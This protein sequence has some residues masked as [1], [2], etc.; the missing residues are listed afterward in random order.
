MTKACASFFAILILTSYA[1]V[2]LFDGAPPPRRNSFIMYQDYYNLRPLPCECEKS[3][4]IPPMVEIE[5]PRAIRL[6]GTEEFRDVIEIRHDVIV[7]YLANWCNTSQA[8]RPLLHDLL[9]N[10]SMPK[11]LVVAEVIC[12]PGESNDNCWYDDTH[13]S[14]AV[15]PRLHW[16][17]YNFTHP[18]SKASA[19][20]TKLLLYLGSYMRDT[21]QIPSTSQWWVQYAL[22][23]STA[24]HKLS[25]YARVQRYR[26][27]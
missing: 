15:F 11:Y 6:D 26:G 2:F 1:S 17:S 25:D 12:T 21:R 4:Y 9:A 20:Y 5:V 27:Q 10:E 16:Y 18:S 3:R 8:I 19:V 7:V 24:S 22:E 13:Q 23:Q 14:H